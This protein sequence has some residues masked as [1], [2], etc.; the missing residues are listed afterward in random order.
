MV[1]TYSCNGCASKKMHEQVIKD[2]VI[3]WLAQ[4]EI[5]PEQVTFILDRMRPE[6]IKKLSEK[7]VCK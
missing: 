5:S 7:A 4:A 3:T 1:I 6:Q 2:D